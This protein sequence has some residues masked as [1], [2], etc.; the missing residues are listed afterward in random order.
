MAYEVNDRIEVLA[1]FGRRGIVPR[2]FIWKSRR[3]PIAKVTAT[4]T[5]PAGLFHQHHFA[6]LT[7]E[8]VDLYE[9]CFHPR[10]LAWH[11]LRIHGDQ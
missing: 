9:I 10:D 8:A 1:A 7:P 6:V 5:E 3:Y 4:W 11:L 2:L